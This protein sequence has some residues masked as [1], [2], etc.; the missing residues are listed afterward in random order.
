MPDGKLFL[1]TAPVSI[2]TVGTG[3]FLYDPVTGDIDPSFIEEAAEDFLKQNTLYHAIFLGGGRL[4]IATLNGGFVIIDEDGKMIQKFNKESG[5][6]DQQVTYAYVN[7]ENP[8]QS[9]LWLTLNNGISKAEINSP[10]RY[11]GESSGIQGTIN[12][13]IRFNGTLYIATSMAVF[14]QVEN[15]DG[16]VEFRSI[17]G[18]TSQVYDLTLYTPPDGG[19]ERL[20]FATVVGLYEVTG[21]GQAR[22]LALS[23]RNTAPGKRYDLRQA[24]QSIINPHHLLLAGESFYTLNLEGNLITQ[25]QDIDMQD[26]IQTVAEDDN[27][28][29]WLTTSQKGVTRVSGSS[30]DPVLINYNMGHGLPSAEKNYV[31]RLDNEILF[32]TTQGIYRFSSESETFYADTVIGEVFHSN[33][34]SV[35]RITKD[36][37]ERY[38]ISYEKDGQYREAIVSQD[39]DKIST[40]L[41]PFYRLPNKSTDVFFD[42]GETVWLGKSTELYRFDDK[43]DKNYHLPFYSLVRQVTLSMDSI[44]FYG[45]DFLLTPE[46]RRIVSFKQN[47]QLKPS[48]K[49]SYN[50]LMI[51]LSA[52]FFESEGA[53]LYRFWLE[54]S[55]PAWT[56]WVSRDFFERPNLRPGQYKLHVQARN[57]YG[58]ESDIDNYEF[59]ILP[60]WY[61]HPIAY[62]AYVILLIILIIVIVRLYTRR[63]IKENIKLEGIIEERTAEIRRQKEELEDSIEYASRIQ[64]ALLPS[65]KLLQEEYPDHFILFK[66]RDIVSG[67]FYW[68]GKQEGKLVIVAADCTGHGVPG[69]FMSMLGITF[70]NEVVNKNRILEPNKILDELRDHVMVSL[71]QTGEEEDETKDGMDLALMVIDKEKKTL[72]Y[73]GAYNPLYFVRPLTQEEKEKVAKGEELDL[74]HGGLNNENFLLEQLD[75]DK[76]PI[77]I[78]I[79]HAQP[80]TMREIEMKPGYTIY[81]NSDGYVDQFG[82][83]RGKKFMSKNFKKLILELQETPM[84][85]QGKILDERLLEWQGEDHPQID[86]IIVIGINCGK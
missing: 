39:G 72:Q 15:P 47:E 26:M 34:T 48:V 44:V 41:L 57:V 58:V 22:D 46:G 13:I 80:F 16:T 65:H 78:S 76:M 21:P 43:Y 37:Q 53:T 83:P 63:L 61:Q 14:Y 33:N 6:Q 4:G 45:T 11:F 10:I 30:D 42:D 82:G 51:T 71:K 85:R 56:L 27:G 81:I 86:D 62:I 60:P 67:D 49:Y 75:A 1:G 24:V 52:P 29:I 12:D 69:A 23:I 79:K 32:A 36:T 19:K 2:N 84:K 55:D 50:N 68:M 7:P 5:L 70:L 54:G 59:T 38:W 25:V 8:D 35:F 73:S 77:G 17:P 18:V 28:D 40:D 31:Y 9:P 3:T 20:F 74:S 66:P 64:Q